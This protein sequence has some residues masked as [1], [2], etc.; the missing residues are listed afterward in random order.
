MI[1]EFVGYF[2]CV[3]VNA[4]CTCLY[5][6]ERGRGLREKKKRKKKKERQLLTIAMLLLPQI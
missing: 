3:G 4:M 5:V 6:C 1:L 2:V